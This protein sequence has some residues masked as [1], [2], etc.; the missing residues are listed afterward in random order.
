MGTA[1]AVGAR[2]GRLL[3]RISLIGRRVGCSQE[4]ARSSR[5]ESDLAPDQLVPPR[6]ALRSAS[7]ERHQ[8]GLTGMGC[9]P[10]VRHNDRACDVRRIIGCKERGDVG[11]FVRSAAT[12]HWNY[13]I[14]KWTHR[15]CFQPAG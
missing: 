13:L 5:F 1:R 15:H 14:P 7:H 9:Q 12:P 8:V 2:G 4:Q 6:G 3:P 11:H 10:T